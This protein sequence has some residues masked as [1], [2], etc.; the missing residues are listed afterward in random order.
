MLCNSPVIQPPNWELPFRCHVD[1]SELAVG[2]T[3]TQLYNAGHDRAV[4]F[5]YKR[6]SQ[7]EENYSAN[8]R[9]LLGLVH[10]LKRLRCYLEG[11]EFEV[12]TD[13]QV[14]RHLLQKQS[15]VEEKRDG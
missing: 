10:F 2:G 6:L 4:A 14:L 1:E 11:S 3:L 9:E 12:I 15:S 8:D 5:Y 7:A 13:N